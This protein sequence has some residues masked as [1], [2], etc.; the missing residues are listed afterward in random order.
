MYQEIIIKGAREHNLKNINI[1]IPK[2]KLVVISGL[3]GSG[4][5]SLAFHTL[6]A[7]GHNRYIQSLSAYSRQFLGNLKKPAVD[8]IEG[9]SPSISIDQKKNSHNPRS[10]VA[11]LTEI[12]DYLR[13]LY[14]RIGDVYCPHG[15]GLIEST[16]CNKILETLLK[17]SLGKQIFVKSPVARDEMQIQKIFFEKL[18]NDGYIRVEVDKKMYNL[19][20]ELD[21][22]K[23]DPNIK[24]NV[25]VIIDRVIVK[26]DE[27]SQHRIIEGLEQAADLSFGFIL[28]E[29]FTDNTEHLYSKNYMCKVCGFHVPNLEPKHFSFNSPA[30]AC[31]DC[32]GLGYKLRYDIDKLV[33]NKNLTIAEGAIVYFKSDFFNKEYN[34]LVKVCQDYDIDIYKAFKNLTKKEI[35]IIFEGTSE[36]L[37]SKHSLKHYEGI[38]NKI[39]RLYLATDSD[40]SHIFYHQYLS[41]KIC[42]TCHGDRL[43]QQSLTVFINK[44]NI[45]QFCRLTIEECYDFLIN[46]KLTPFKQKIADLVLK[47]IIDRLRF[48]KEVGLEYLTL[49]RTAKTLSGGESQRIKLA[50]QLGTKLTGILYVLDEPSIGLHPRDNNRLIKSLKNMVEIGNTLVVVEHD[51]EM[52]LSSDHLIDIGPLAGTKGGHVVGEASPEEY[53]IPNNDKLQNSLTAKYLSRQLFI[54][55]PEKFKKTNKFLKIQKANINN[56]KDLDVT[57]PLNN[58]VVITGV[59]GSGKSS[60]VHEVIYQGLLNEI[61]PHDN[62]Y[63]QNYKKMEGIQNIDKVIFVA[64]DPIG[65]TPRSNPA[66]YTSVFD[67]IRDLYAQL[68]ISKVRGYSKSKFSF[69]LPG[70]RC[71]KCKGD[72]II[73]ISMHFLSDLYVVCDACKGKRYNPEILKILYNDK[74]ISDVLNMTVDEAIEFFNA[75][76]AI[77]RKLK[78]LKDVGLG[79]IKLGQQAPHLSGGE[80]QRIKLSKYLQKRPTG[81]TVYIFDE[82][83]VGLH[84][85]D[86]QKIIDIFRLIVENGDS[87]IIIEHNLEII[88]SADHIIDL[89]PEAGDRGGKIIVQGNPIQVS[90]HPTS[91]TGKFLKWKLKVDKII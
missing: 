88:K 59:S 62:K 47:Q 51:E 54:R 87:V 57:I 34:N 10:T 18:K 23:I 65:K 64:Q 46:L 8:L 32:H 36:S 15:H 74:N 78:Y 86:V 79:Y 9:L 69:N 85:H 38:G 1:N 52:L 24:H 72:G 13:L 42:P 22:I 63:P 26:D 11:T 7:E 37:L 3:S 49:E 53:L 20:I 67:D 21:K 19:Q 56:I 41:E 76:P 61:N 66:T 2:N 60:L 43:S 50:S 33:P 30:G 35:K 45:A 25:N 29:N 75:Q 77:F 17:N 40:A 82:P 28:I 48:L 89:G 84:F 80:S 81:K 83:S 55:F 73:K 5:S 91:H 90:Q 12:H 44:K 31:P 70:G 6:Y 4:K 14:S 39:Q 68:P 71:D 27:D 58:F 16:D